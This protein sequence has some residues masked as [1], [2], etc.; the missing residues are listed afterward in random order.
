MSNL[1]SLEHFAPRAD[2]ILFLQ[3]AVEASA[4][5][6]A[7]DVGTEGVQSFFAGYKDSIEVMR[8]AA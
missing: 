7:Q 5:Q 2:V 8:M 1:L 4:R 6:V 3:D